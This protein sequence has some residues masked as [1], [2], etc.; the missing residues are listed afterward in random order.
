LKEAKPDLQVAI[1][2][3]APEEVPDLPTLPEKQ[4]FFQEKTADAAV[5]LAAHMTTLDGPEL[6]RAADKLLKAAQT[7]RASLKLDKEAHS[8]IQIAVLASSPAKLARDRR[9]LEERE[10]K[11][12]HSHSSH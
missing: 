9:M 6:V 7:A 10:N 1:V 4:Q 12:R 5:K 8:V 2:S 3:A 11:P